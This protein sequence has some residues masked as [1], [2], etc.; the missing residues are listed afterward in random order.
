MMMMMKYELKYKLFHELKYHYLK[1][2]VLG[3]GADSVGTTGNLPRY[4]SAAYF[5][6]CSE[7]AIITLN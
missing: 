6:F 3:I 4:L 1:H 2:T 7:N 5:D